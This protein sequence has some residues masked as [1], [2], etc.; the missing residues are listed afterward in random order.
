MSDLFELA[1]KYDSVKGR[2]KYKHNLHTLTKL[3]PELF[4]T[5]LNAKSILEIGIWDGGGLL[6]LRDYFPKAKIIGL[7]IRVPLK[8]LSQERVTVLIGDQGK[9]EELEQLLP[10]VP[11]DIIIDDGSH[12]L[13][14]IATSF[15][16]LWPHVSEGGLYII[17]DT[18]HSYNKGQEGSVIEF[19]KNLVHQKF[20]RTHTDMYSVSF[21][22]N[23][24]VIEKRT[25]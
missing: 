22:L 23:T 21:A 10:Y 14:D 16:F 6:M 20:I 15:K 8:D 17:E 11:Y 5:R 3:Y 13:A 24:V 4:R 9:K 12:I 19:A 2:T 18:E 7:D 25:L 1:Q